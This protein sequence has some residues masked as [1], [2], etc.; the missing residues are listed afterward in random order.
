MLHT[1]NRE[2]LYRAYNRIERVPPHDLL[3]AAK[4][5]ELDVVVA[6]IGDRASARDAVHGRTALCL[7][8][9]NGHTDVVE[10]DAPHELIWIGLR[11][12]N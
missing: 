2:E 11:P 1:S 3:T 4:Q 6:H 5:G 12:T 10:Q 8:A 7:A 9:E